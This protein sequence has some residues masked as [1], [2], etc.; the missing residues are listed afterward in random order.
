MDRSS[1]WKVTSEIDR[2]AL[3]AGDEDGAVEPLIE[4]LS[5]HSEQEV[6]SFA[7]HLAQMLF[8]LD[9]QNYADE[10]GES[11]GSDDGFL[12]SRCFVVACGQEHFEAVKAD[13]TKMPKD[14]EEWC[15][16]L[17]YAARYAWAE[18][19]GRDD[20]D[21]DHVSPVS[22]EKGSNTALWK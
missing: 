13:P 4:A 5:K 9:G 21:W 6:L 8:D 15:E 12:Y 20:D 3:R 10:A 18:V 22:Y 11:G 1:F 17:L 19:T 16:S 2:G 7:D 14:L